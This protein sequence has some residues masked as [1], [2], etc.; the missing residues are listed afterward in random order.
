LGHQKYKNRNAKRVRT[1]EQYPNYLFINNLYFSITNYYSLV[2]AASS[3]QNRNGTVKKNT[4]SEF[5]GFSPKD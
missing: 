3:L 4:N 5:Q 2:I 1:Y